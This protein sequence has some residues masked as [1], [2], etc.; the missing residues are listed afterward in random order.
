MTRDKDEI[1]YPVPNFFA[2]WAAFQVSGEL[3][4][5]YVAPPST[6]GLKNNIHHL[7]NE[8][9]IEEKAW[10]YEEANKRRIP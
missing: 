10:A 3:H 6:V 1:R 9:G 5:T 4:G 2:L 8:H 7:Q